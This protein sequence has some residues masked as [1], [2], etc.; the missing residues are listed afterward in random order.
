M[1]LKKVHD[2]NVSLGTILKSL[3]TK[4][5]VVEVAG[6]KGYVLLPLDDDLIDS[7]LER[8]PKLIKECRQLRARM[9]A[10]QFVT[11]DQVKKRLGA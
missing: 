5:G 8:S 7:L 2:L 9:A 11:H 3:G 1:K 10:G 6:K 4:G